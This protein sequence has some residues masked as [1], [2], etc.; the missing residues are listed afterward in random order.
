MSR[1]IVYLNGSFLPVH[2]A[3]VSVMDRGFLFGD[4]V[5]EVIPVY[6]GR[7]FRLE[8][9][10]QRLD[11]SLQGVR[12]ANPLDHVQWSDILIALIRHNGGGDQSIY[13]QVTR[14]VAPT[15]DHAFPADVQ[16]TV[17]AMSTPLTEPAAAVRAGVAAVT[18][19][20]IRWKHCNIKAITLL[21]NVLMRQQ[22]LDAGAAEAILLRDGLATEGAA[23]NLFIVSGGTVLTPP[24]SN[25][26]LPGITRDLV[27]ELCQA[28]GIPCCEADISADE[29]RSAD[30]VWIS[31]STREVVPIT[32]LD[33]APVGD[34]KPGPL[35][36]QVSALYSAYKQDFRAGK[37]Q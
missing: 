26:L 5:Y 1:D 14:G 17:F 11:L 35:W 25:L 36:Q 9:H 20:D 37:V 6:G 24:K 29:L 8:H 10:L 16:P 12:I 31:S 3:T 19:D 18:I 32:R 27:V 4:G 34:G 15:R 21:P 28:H 7:A 13:L 23:S 30:E 33:D 22:A 2:E